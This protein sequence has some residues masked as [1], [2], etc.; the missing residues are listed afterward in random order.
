MHP[1]QTIPQSRQ[2]DEEGTDLAYSAVMPIAQPIV[3]HTGSAHE[4]LV[5]VLPMTLPITEAMRQELAAA[6]A[7]RRE[8]E[9]EAFDDSDNLYDNVACTD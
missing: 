8:A 4:A 7:K 5:A 1:L 9:A 3:G 2:L 6:D